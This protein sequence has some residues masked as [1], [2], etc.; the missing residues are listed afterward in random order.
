MRWILPDDGGGR[1]LNVVEYSLTF[2]KNHLI[3]RIFGKDF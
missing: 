1:H 3:V 2:F